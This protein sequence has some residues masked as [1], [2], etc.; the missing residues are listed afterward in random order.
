[1][2]IV[3]RCKQCGKELR[4]KDELAGKTVRCPGCQSP[5]KIEPAGSASGSAAPAAPKNGPASNGPK[6][7]VNVNAAIAKVEA[8]RQKREA[9]VAEKGN[10]ES[11]VEK[12]VAEF[13]KVQPKAGA[14]QAE[15]EKKRDPNKTDLLA[16]AQPVTTATKAADFW[17]S[18]KASPSF[19]YVVI[20]VLL[21]AGAIGSQQIISR[22][23]KATVSETVGQ[24]VTDEMAK[25][26]LTKAEKAFE[27]GN[28]G[29]VRQLLPQILLGNPHRKNWIRY[30]QLRQKV[31]AASKR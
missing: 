10:R 14:K 12:L 1:M 6:S 7:G 15:Q 31:E 27:A 4:A 11:V 16:K 17:G 30:D 24:P 13:D 22:V 3:V 8:A 18:M 29:E 5:L 20:V 28:L 23:M 21:A 2:A 26:M 19:K 25:E 9:T